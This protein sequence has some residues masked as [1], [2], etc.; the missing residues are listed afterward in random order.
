MSLW[1]WKIINQRMIRRGLYSE[2]WFP[3]LYKTN[4][5]L[6]VVSISF[7]H[8]KSWNEIQECVVIQGIPTK[9][10][11]IESRPSF[12]KHAQLGLSLTS[13]HCLWSAI[14]VITVSSVSDVSTTL[15]TIMSKRF[16][17]HWWLDGSIHYDQACTTG[18]Y[19]GSYTPCIGSRFFCPSLYCLS[20]RS[21]MYA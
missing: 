18:C 15:C 6:S 8:I 19:G 13:G 14:R 11:S 1:K 9:M 20:G 3:Y 5:S 2:I 12:T 10:H 4:C 21:V 7:N 16:L 17:G